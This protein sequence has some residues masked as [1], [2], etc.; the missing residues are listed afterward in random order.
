MT[1]PLYK[2]TIKF[3]ASR[4]PSHFAI[5]EDITAINLQLSSELQLSTPWICRE[6]NDASVNAL[7][8][9]KS[10]ILQVVAVLPVQPQAFAANPH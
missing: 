2:T 10:E 6:F 8:K 3:S 5:A 4:S 9:N 7:G 1:Q